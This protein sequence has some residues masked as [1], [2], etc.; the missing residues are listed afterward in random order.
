[1]GPAHLRGHLAVDL[2]ED[3]L[4]EAEDGVHG[5]A[6][7]VAHVGE[8]LRLGLARPRELGV[9]RLEL[10]G[11]R[12]LLLVE[13]AELGA[14]PVHL[15]GELAELVAI[16][17]G[18]GGAEVSLGHLAEKGLGLPDGKDERPRGDEAEEKGK[19]ERR[20]HEAAHEIE[21]VAIGTRGGRPLLGH[22]LFLDAN[23]QLD[24]ALDLPEERVAGLELELHGLVDLAVADEVGHVGHRGHDVALGAPDALD[25]L[26]LLGGA[27]RSRSPRAWY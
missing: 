27:R 22:V 19:E 9:E 13:P 14:H 8:E 11:G 7:L 3:H 24:E 10:A 5:R 25:D 18:D 4:G 21:G 2:V 6:E 17:D 26:A 16:V 1:M 20:H 12:P 15:R 23:D